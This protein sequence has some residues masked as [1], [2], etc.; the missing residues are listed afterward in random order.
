MNNK[1]PLPPSNSPIDTCTVSDKVYLWIKNAIINGEF[2]PGERIIQETLT[3]QLQV[4]RT[5]VRDALQRL[6]TEGLV[7][8]KPFHGAEVFELS[9][10][11][12]HEVYEIRTLLENYAAQKAMRLITQEELQK[13]EQ[14]NSQLEKCKS[15]MQACM[16]Y[17]REFH[18]AICEAGRSEYIMDILK[19]AWDKSDPYKSIYFTLPGNSERSIIEHQEMIRCLRNKDGDSLTK[20]VDHHLRDV[21]NMISRYS[22]VFK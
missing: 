4:S 22:K 16:A 2:Q 3:Q 12:L 8:I 10:E 7:V 20:A 15:D 1:Q 13:L 5:P 9:S 17:D 19:G 18:C 11:S 21:V 6:N 14:I